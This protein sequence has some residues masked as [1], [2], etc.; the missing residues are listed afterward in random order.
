MLWLSNEVLRIIQ[1]DFGHV[2]TILTHPTEH[3]R[4]LQ[5]S[6][7]VDNLD[8]RKQDMF[9]NIELLNHISSGCDLRK[10]YLAISASGT[11]Q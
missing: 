3:P 7:Q 8:I 5:Y 2:N 4:E 10:K 11:E 9:L 6:L 1:V